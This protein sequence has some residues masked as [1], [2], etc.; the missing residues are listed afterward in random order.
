MEKINY[1]NYEIM[2]V[3][4]LN[5]WE[6]VTNARVQ[7]EITERIENTGKL[8]QFVRDKLWKWEILNTRKMCSYKFTTRL[9]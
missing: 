6:L 4:S 8:Y 5:T 3:K 1:N 2:K 7:E 9:F